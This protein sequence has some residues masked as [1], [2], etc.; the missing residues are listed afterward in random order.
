MSELDRPSLWE[1]LA[2]SSSSWGSGAGETSASTPRRTR[3]AA[4]EMAVTLLIRVVST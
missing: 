2:V 1:A 4:A 3:T